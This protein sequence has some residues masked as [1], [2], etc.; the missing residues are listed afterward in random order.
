MKVIQ[1]IREIRFR[2]SFSIPLKRFFLLVQACSIIFL[3]ATLSHE[4]FNL[5]KTA[6]AKVSIALLSS[7]LFSFI[8]LPLSQYGMLRN[9]NAMLVTFEAILMAAVWST[10]FS[11]D[12]WFTFK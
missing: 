8:Q 6:D 2:N 7:I 12:V 3:V 4:A 11:I 9:M 10:C 1:L 5:R